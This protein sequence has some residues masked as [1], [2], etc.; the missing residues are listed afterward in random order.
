MLVSHRK[1]FIY[2]KT[3]KTASTSVECY[4]ERYCLQKNTYV[5]SHAR[6]ESISKFGIIGYRGRLSVGY[7][8]YNHMPAK[9][10]KAKL[11]DETWND[12]FKFCTVRNPYTRLVSLFHMELKLLGIINFNQ[13]N[14]RQLF[15]NWLTMR[16]EWDFSSTRFFMLDN[17]VCLDSFIRFEYLKED[18]KRI[19]NKLSIPYDEARLPYLKEGS[20]TKDYLAYY[21]Q[22]TIALVKKFCAIELDLFK[23][24][25]PKK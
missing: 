21:D 25:F 5:F 9:D 23:Y 14:L 11:I 16:Y 1:K 24:S 18:T 13:K 19:C 7:D 4:F 10:L 3:I 22:H 8:F 20:Y 6:N 15:S 12:Y 2:L 17:E